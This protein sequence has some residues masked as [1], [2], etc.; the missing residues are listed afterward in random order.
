M[1]PTALCWNAFDEFDAITGTQGVRQG[2]TKK[3][4]DLPAAQPLIC[5]R[6]MWSDFC[7][8]FA[9]TLEW[10][11]DAGRTYRQA[12]DEAVGYQERKAALLRLGP[13]VH[14]L[15]ADPAAKTFS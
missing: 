4:R 15:R 10:T 7:D 11:A 12:K 3:T 5:E 13:F 2:V 8:R 6:R 9:A 14:W 1:T